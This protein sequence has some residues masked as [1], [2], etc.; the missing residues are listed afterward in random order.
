MD[1]EEFNYGVCF[2]TALRKSC[3]TKASVLLW[4]M[5]HVIM[6]ADDEVGRSNRVW[7]NFNTWCDAKFKEDTTQDFFGVALAWCETNSRT[8]KHGNPRTG[9]AHMFTTALELACEETRSDL[10][11]TAEYWLKGS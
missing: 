6:Q 2:H 4:N 7:Y 1:L 10:N 11:Y 3:D 5:I 8:E 9:T